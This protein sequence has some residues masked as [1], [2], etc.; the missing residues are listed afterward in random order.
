MNSGIN[1]E[2]LSQLITDV[3]LSDN[4]LEFVPFVLF[5]LPSLKKLNLSNNKL[6][7][8]PCSTKEFSQISR[9]SD[10]NIYDKNLICLSLEELDLQHNELTVLPD[11]IFQMHNLQSINCSHNKVHKLPFEM[12]L[13]ESLKVLILHHNCLSQLP[14]LVSNGNFKR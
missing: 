5:Q 12:W 11:Y 8:L 9:E 4:N 13:S 3:N 1:N 2:L 14:V 6:A 10:F 7:E